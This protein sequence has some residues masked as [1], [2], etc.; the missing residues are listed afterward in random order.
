MT[1]LRILQEHYVDKLHHN[2]IIFFLVFFYGGLGAAADPYHISIDGVAHSG[3]HWLRE[4]SSTVSTAK[5]G[6]ITARV[7]ASRFSYSLKLSPGQKIMRFHFQP[8][9]YIGFE[10]SNDF[11]SVEAGNSS[12]LADFSASVTAHALAVNVIVKQFCVTVEEN[13][14][15]NLDFSPALGNSYAFVNGIDIISIPSITSPYCDSRVA[16]NPIIHVDSSTALERVH[17]QHVKWGPVSS[18]DD[19]ASMFGVWAE[20]PSVGE[21]AEMATNKTWI[22]YVDVGFDYMV[23]LHF[24]EIGLH[25][26]FVL[27]VNGRVALT[28]ADILQQRR[29]N[30]EFFW[31]N[32]YV[33]MDE[34]LKQGDISVSLHSRHEF[35]DRRG[36]LEGF[37]VFKI[38]SHHSPSWT[39]LRPLRF[40]SYIT[41]ILHIC[42]I[43]F[44]FYLEDKMSR[45]E[46][47]NEDNKPSSLSH[48]FS[49]AG[50]LRI[51]EYDGVGKGFMDCGREIVG[52]N[53]FG[54]DSKQR[55]NKFWTVIEPKQMI[56]VDKYTPNGKL[57][58]HLDKLERKRKQSQ[59]CIEVSRA[60]KCL[61]TGP[62]IIHKDL[63]PG[64][65]LLDNKFEA[66]L[67]DFDLA[68]T[69]SFNESQSQDSTKLIGTCGYTG[70]GFITSGEL[71]KKSNIFSS[72]AL[73]MKVMF[74]RAAREPLRE[75]DKCILT[76][77]AERTKVEDDD[78]DKSQQENMNL[79]VPNEKIG[80]DNH[81]RWISIPRLWLR[82]VYTR[83]T[84]YLPTERLST[85]YKS[86]YNKKSAVSAQ[87]KLRLLATGLQEWQ[88]PQVQV[89][90]VLGE[91]GFG[92][93]Y[94][95]FMNSE[96]DQGFREWE[97]KSVVIIASLTGSQKCQ[98]P[99][100]VRF[101][102]SDEELMIY[103]LSKKLKWVSAPLDIDHYDYYPWNLSK[104]SFSGE[105][106]WFN[107]SRWDG[108]RAWGATSRHQKATR[109]LMPVIL[110]GAGKYTLMREYILEEK[111]A[112]Y[113]YFKANKILLDELYRAKLSALTTLWQLE[114]GVLMGSQ[115]RQ[116]CLKIRLHPTNEEDYGHYY[117]PWDLPK[118]SF[119]EEQEWFYFSPR[120][121]KRTQGATSGHQKATGM[122]SPVV[123][124]GITEWA[125]MLMGSQKRQM[126]LKI[127]LHPTNEE[128]YGH[129][130][131]PW[132]LPKWSFFGEQEWFY[133]SPRDR[134]RTQGAT[135]GHQ[136][137]TGMHSPVVPIGITEWAMML[138]HMLEDDTNC[139]Y[140]QYN[141]W[142]K[143][144]IMIEYPPSALPLQKLTFKPH[145]K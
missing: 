90:W 45:C 58:D 91:G 66:R 115:K 114:L 112:I 46:F 8:S 56:L 113:R 53:P 116:M 134:K 63:K 2:M 34:E 6:L 25:M 139:P 142:L 64:N 39:L 126:R 120:D 138:E 106:E 133:F 18:G 32:N 143:H 67:S 87:V 36:P 61:H 82:P 71:T 5:G 135:S 62:M 69:L 23:R 73:M 121:R 65:V 92:R 96:S 109:M 98:M 10:S 9:S 97:A 19:I 24:C 77:L 78:Y 15:L 57:P 105:N 140:R 47:T 101:H 33:V 84:F 141:D 122:H 85:V 1:S 136:K 75:E 76:T 130:Y 11:F 104:R 117:K 94:K 102:P 3:R 108:K 44:I 132:D 100:G 17:Y 137:A 103:Y 43:V 89:P 111:S 54:I 99:P 80:I 131:K 31:Y 145:W 83:D 72:G 70:P 125:M 129:Y 118:W 27:L 144:M 88:M 20:Q 128:D 38:S 26:D 16:P 40:F 110:S 49:L 124:I 60:L 14:T 7:S 59:I 4:G 123:P 13:E 107:F 74:G 48:R 81:V 28:S 79:I 35:M 51:C 55:E 86:L 68:K 119:F 29:G 12:L 37:E 52:I 30:R 21:D 22:A 50:I 42:C 93:V 95:R 127:R 41:I